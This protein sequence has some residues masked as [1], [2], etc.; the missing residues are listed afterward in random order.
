MP[1]PYFSISVIRPD[2]LLKL[3]F[4]FINLTLNTRITPLQL[5]HIDPT[6]PTFLIV[7]F[8]PQHIAEEAFFE[9]DKNIEIPKDIPKDRQDFLT[10]P[11]PPLPDDDKIKTPV[12]SIMA[13]NSRLVFLIPKSIR[14]IPYTLKSLL[15]WSKYDL[16]VVPVAIPPP[17]VISGTARVQPFLLDT[18]TN[19]LK[20]V[21]FETDQT[22]GKSI[23]KIR[24][25]NPKTDK[26]E[27]YT[28]NSNGPQKPKAVETS[29]EAPYRL[30]L[31]P[32]MFA[33]WAHSILPV[34]QRSGR[35][36]LWHTRLGI[37]KPGG[38]E[39]FYDYNR[40]VRAVWMEDY[41]R[42]PEPPLSFNFLPFKNTSLTKRDLWE[43][44]KLT[45]D[46]KGWENRI[47]QVNRLMLTSLGAWMNLRYAND[48]TPESTL[49]LEEWRHIASMG[50]DQY[51]RVV[52]KG[53]LLPFGFPASLIRITERKFKTNIE[54]K[55]V[56]AL[57]QRYFVVVRHPTVSYKEQNQK[58]EGRS[59]PFK[60]VT[61]TT[62]VTPNLDPPINSQILTHGQS[63]FWVKVKDNYFKFHI[64]A[65][66]SDGQ[67]CEFELPF[68][69]IDNSIIKSTPSLVPK[70]IT[71]YNIEVVSKPETKARRMCNLF[72]QKIALVPDATYEIKSIEFA[73]EQ[74][75]EGEPLALPC[76]PKITK[77]EI[78]DPSM[79]Q[80]TG[81]E[82]AKKAINISYHPTYLDKGFTDKKGNA[83]A[84]VFA[85]LNTPAVSLTFPTD[86]CGGI[87]TP[88]MNLIGFSRKFG[89]LGGSNT[90]SLN[91]LAGTSEDAKFDP[92][93]YFAGSNAKLLGGID[94]S[95]IILNSFDGKNGSNLPQIRTTPIYAG[96]T[97][98]GSPQAIKTVLTWKPDIQESK[99]KVF[100]PIKD[101]SQLSI[102]TTIITGKKDSDSSSTVDG[103][104][105]N[106]SIDLLGFVIIKFA[107]FTFH[108]EKGKKLAVD[109]KISDVEFDGPLKF[110]KELKNY[111]P[112]SGTGLDVDV[113]P[114]G[115]TIG[116]TLSIPT[117]GM[118]V[119]TI[120]NIAFNAGINLPFTG[121]A[122]R[123]RFAFCKREHPFILTVYGLGG[124]GF[125]SLH[126]G[127]DGVELLEASLEFGA[128][129]ALNIGVASGEVHIMAGIYYKWDPTK[130]ALLEGYL[131]LGGELEVLGIISVS[132]EFYMALA[133][134]SEGGDDKVW[135]EA[136]LTVQIR[137]A[138]FR[139]SVV[140]KVRREFVDPNRIT[141]QQYMPQRAWEEE[142]CEA[143]A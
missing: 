81:K 82:N 48:I 80:I 16:N 94:L 2:D 79:I 5:E 35:V 57:I 77:A 126:L 21:T 3:D 52:Y 38:V 113:T 112:I 143:F 69:F 32:N 123:L 132:V 122:A 4:T 86:K 17:Q 67:H 50:R 104:L 93:D 92:I 87:A 11:S 8:P 103:S 97:K 39:E 137:I 13:K 116:S 90:D 121:E 63:A 108:G 27:K 142:Y 110:V 24:P 54:G 49:T 46:F 6:L 60:T 61:V 55:M 106:F 75:K 65:E 118:G 10:P 127:L 47:I 125:F 111:L 68:L 41:V 128:S 7:E 91:K 95:E 42:D 44:V 25:F 53:Y 43:L 37:K 99:N 51:V 22:T 45:A 29:I 18:H 135:G 70:I 131:R 15:D 76:F 9:I 64:I 23:E 138:F 130:G 26:Y 78:Y 40:T 133:F 20:I 114:A 119:V 117:I 139:K 66:D 14:R 141:F 120:Q 72:E 30:I 109:P 1:Q 28:V 89:P 12:F 58:Y 134:S 102:E 98:T 36:E 124:G 34:S 71:E 101:I 96:D 88:N 56:A 73:L 62:L 115:V 140:L 84:E 74:S 85:M 33:G 107:S 19:E 129:V 105:T 31:S 136:S 83:N 59:N 100:K